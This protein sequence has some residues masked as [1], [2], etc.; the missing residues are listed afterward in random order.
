MAEVCNMVVSVV[1]MIKTKQFSYSM[2]NINIW[3]LLKISF[4]METSKEIE[5]APA[6]D[7]FLEHRCDSVYKTV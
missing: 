3:I 4:K 5:P 6:Q 1:L 7:L 2:K